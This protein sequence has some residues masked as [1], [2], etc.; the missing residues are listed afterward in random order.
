MC[1]L[2]AKG[3]Q[4]HRIFPSLGSRTLQNFDTK[5]FAVNIKQ[6]FLETQNWLVHMQ[7]N[8]KIQNTFTLY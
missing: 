5:T 1:F 7:H 4:A 3:T 8:S 6:G 2:D